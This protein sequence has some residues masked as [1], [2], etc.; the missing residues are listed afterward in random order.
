MRTE[1][2]VRRAVETCLSFIAVLDN[3]DQTKRTLSGIWTA[4]EWV[5]ETDDGRSFES[6]MDSLAKLKQRAAER[7]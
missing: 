3:R 1:S 7:N 2:E 4:L 6:L 5:I